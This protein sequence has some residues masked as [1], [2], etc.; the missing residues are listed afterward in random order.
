MRYMGLTPTDPGNLFYDLYSS[1]GNH[2]SLSGSYLAAVVIYATIT[3]ND[4]VG[5]P[6]STSLSD[7]VVIKLQKAATATVFYETCHLYD[8]PWMR[9]QPA[10]WQSCK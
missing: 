4:P 9:E 8:Y 3:G 6:N 5:L 1:D 7:D 10:H 2:P